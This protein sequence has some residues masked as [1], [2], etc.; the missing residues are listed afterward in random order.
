MPAQTLKLVRSTLPLSNWTV[1][2]A[3]IYGLVLGATLLNESSD[4]A[5]AMGIS[6][7]LS[8]AVGCWLA[9][10]LYRLLTRGYVAW[11]T[12]IAARAENVPA[13]QPGL[14]DAAKQEAADGQRASVAARLV[15][16]SFYLTLLAVSAFMSSVLSTVLMYQIAGAAIL[17]LAF[18]V[19]IFI[20]L[21][22]LIAVQCLYFA[23]L[24][25]K[26]ASIEQAIERVGTVEPGPA[27]ISSRVAVLDASMTR[28]ER[29]GR[30]FIGTGPSP[31]ERAAV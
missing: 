22:T 19:S 17:Q 23:Y 1:T 9:I 10:Y 24:H 27:L 26:V 4:L 21:T 14:S 15:A 12:R 16:R 28:T 5:T 6:G 8:I 31:S 3:A 18:S 13:L 20:V 25:W 2:V 7:F 11:I 29:F 30:R